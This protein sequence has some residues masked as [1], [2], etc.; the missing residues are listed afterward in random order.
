MYL[1]DSKSKRSIVT[2]PK[3]NNSKNTTQNKMENSRVKCTFSGCLKSYSS[4]KNMNQHFKRYHQKKQFQCPTCEKILIS[5]FSLQRH[6][7]SVHEKN[8][9]STESEQVVI[10]RNSVKIAP[11]AKNALIREQAN[12]IEELEEEIKMLESVK[13]ELLQQLTAENKE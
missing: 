9:S 10:K 5:S 6:C 3:G 11:N 13:F 7:Q 4:T 1:K 2:Q 8:I 12:R